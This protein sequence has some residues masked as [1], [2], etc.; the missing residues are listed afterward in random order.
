MGVTSEWKDMF[1]ILIKR[2][3]II[4]MGGRKKDGSENNL[5]HIIIREGIG[6]MVKR[7]RFVWLKLKENQFLF[8][9][10]NQRESF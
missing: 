5:K 9:S 8:V 10:F 6:Y 4:I 3:K 2:K 7:K 1:N